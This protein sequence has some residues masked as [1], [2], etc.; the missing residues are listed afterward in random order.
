LTAATVAGIALFGLLQWYLAAS[1]TK[2][3]SVDLMRIPVMAD[4]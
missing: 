1:R 2:I 4:S 3:D